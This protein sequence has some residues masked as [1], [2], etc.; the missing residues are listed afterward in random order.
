MLVPD[1]GVTALRRPDPRPDRVREP[2][3]RR[4]GAA[5]VGRLPDL[6]PG[7]R[8]RRPPDADQPRHA[9]RGVDLQ[10]P[11]ARAALR[12]A[13]LADADV[14]PLPAAAQREHEQDLEAQEPLVDAR[15][16]PRAGLPAGGAAQLPGADGLV[17]AGRPRDLLAR[18]VHRERRHRADQHHRP[19][20]RPEQ[21]RLAER[22]LHPPAVALRAGR[23]GPAVPGAGRHRPERPA[24]RGGPAADPGAPEAARRGAGA[25]RLLLRRSRRPTTT[26]CWSRRGST[27]RPPRRCWRGDRDRQRRALVRPRHARSE[28]PRACRRTAASRP[29][30]CSCR[31]GS[32]ARSA[33]SRRR[34]SRRWRC[35]AASG[36]SSGWRR[37]RPASGP[38]LLC[39]RRAPGY[40]ARPADAVC[41]AAPRRR[42]SAAPAREDT[43]RSSGPPGHA[44]MPSSARLPRSTAG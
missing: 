35:S 34:S 38:D 10:H 26:R 12:V 31:C 15:L 41:T 24:P 36:C 5:E 3:D 33:T 8:R 29:G 1:E 6:P 37:R 22:P 9:R 39:R 32:P 44:R 19:D 30:S 11:E 17:D 27:A 4:P 18:R 42:R 7:R 14:R 43:P 16:V 13:R 28:P 25:A 20:L 23:A 21:A 2:A 40:R